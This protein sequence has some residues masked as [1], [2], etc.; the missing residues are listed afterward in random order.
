VPDG[1]GC[2]ELS[3]RT[4]SEQLLWSSTSRNAQV[5]RLALFAWIEVDDES[6][7]IARHGHGAPGVVHMIPLRTLLV[8]S[9]GLHALAFA[10]VVELAPGPSPADNP[11]KGLVPYSA[12]G[13]GVFPHS[14]EFDYLRL[15]DLMKGPETFDWQKLDKLLDD[16]ASR[17]NQTIFRVWI[18]YPG[19]DSALP[20]FLREAGVKVTTWRN[21]DE[22]TACHTP[23]Y[24]DERLVSAIESFIAALGQRYDGDPR[25]GCITA[26]L[27]GSWGEWHTY[28]REDL[29]ASV[30]TQERVLAAY[31]N[32]FRKTHVLLRYPV[33][34]DRDDLAPN[35][36]R[37]F[38]YHDD[39]FAWGTLDTGRESDSW[40]FVPSL[41]AAGDAAM[42][43]WRTQ[44]IGGEVRPEV[45]GQIHD[46]E[47][48]HR[49][50]QDFITCVEETHVSWLM[51]SGLFE[52]APDAE[53]HARA[54]AH[55]QRMGYDFHVRTA[56]V[57]REEQYVEI[58]L[59]VVNQGVAPFYQ[60]WRMELAALDAEGRVVKVYPV[61][62]KLT[63]LLPG[64]ARAWAT[65]LE[66]ADSLEGHVLA[67]RVV[68]PLPNGKPLRFANADQDRHAFGWLSIGAVP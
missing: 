50:A 31:E 56:D 38:G 23:D 20:D 7:P 49:Q 42:Q 67:L 6:E 35:A 34:N 37:P 55:V 16:V 62:W 19:Q 21:P 18:E 27:L 11:L 45:W 28:P 51:E 36:E 26:G 30:E 24:E 39:S 68:H 60:D 5:L 12:P 59:S 47:P 13:E 52:N 9:V 58:D 66:I 32:A 8:A 14:L 29:F 17:G 43:K 15:A 10:D 63:E 40:F 25:V 22:G 64:D 53:R 2:I 65:K 33:G 54:T 46:A 61:D 1:E 41:K 57:R 44:P 4:R 3:L 48:R